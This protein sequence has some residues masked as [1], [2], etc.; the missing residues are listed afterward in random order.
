MRKPLMHTRTWWRF[1]TMRVERFKEALRQSSDVLDKDFIEAVQKRRATTWSL[2][3]KLWALQLPIFMFL[4]L[5][6]IPV[7]ASVSIFGVSPEGSKNLREVFV[8]A[9]ALLGVGS[10]CLNHYQDLL[11]E[12]IS[13][14]VD[15]RSKGNKEV[16]EYL[17]MGS[18]TIFWLMPNAKYDDAQ[19]G[20]GF[21]GLVGMIGAIGALVLVT[22][23][24]G[25][26]YIHFLVLKDI[27]SDPSFSS[28][29]ST[30]VIAF[31]LACDCFSILLS[32]LSG[33]GFP[34]Q[35]F[36]NM[37]VVQK[38]NDGNPEKGTKI[39]AAIAKQNVERPW[40]ARFLFGFRMPTKLPRVLTA[41]ALWR[42]DHDSC[43]VSTRSSAASGSGSYFDN[44]AA[45]RRRRSAWLS[46]KSV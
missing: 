33:G 40:I 38:I 12:I 45:I 35:D 32:F 19:L 42:R 16:A 43:L 31:V 22:T 3:L 25:A 18:G 30:L 28:A 46:G 36:T 17:G 11:R 37:Y 20:W 21:L 23:L 5:A 7:H 14:Y 2:T 10:T 29:A 26:G 34:L 9:S 39:F 44:P 15:R 41:P 13:G 24:V 27:Y 6:L 4:V 1:S 8:V